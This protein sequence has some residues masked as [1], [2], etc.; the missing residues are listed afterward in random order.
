MKEIIASGVVI[1]SV[2]EENFLK[3]SKDAN[4]SASIKRIKSHKKAFLKNEKSLK[5]SKKINAKT[6]LFL[7]KNSLISEKTAIKKALKENKQLSDIKISEKNNRKTKQAVLKEITEIKLQEK[8][9]LEF[10]KHIMKTTDY[11]KKKLE[12]KEKNIVKIEKASLKKTDDRKIELE[13]LGI[14]ENLKEENKVGL[15]SYS[16]KK[17]RLLRLTL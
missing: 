3:Y 8:Q 14:K 2:D 4:K 6:E 5:I 13:I 10:F 12:L 1:E 16:R 11:D 9:E 17:T 7:I 15:L